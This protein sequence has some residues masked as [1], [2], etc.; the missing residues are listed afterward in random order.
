MFKDHDA[1]LAHI[2]FVSVTPRAGVWRCKAAVKVWHIR[3]AIDLI[4]GKVWAS[5]KVSSRA[6]RVLELEPWVELAT[7][8]EMEF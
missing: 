7:S 3:W 5:E 1:D 4:R 8:R 2:I 6:A